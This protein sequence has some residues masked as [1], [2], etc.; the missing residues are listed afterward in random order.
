[1][2]KVFEPNDLEIAIRSGKTAICA[3]AAQSYGDL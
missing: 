3:A 2:D 1:M